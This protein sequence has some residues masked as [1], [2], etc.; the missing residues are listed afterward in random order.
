MAST[1]LERRLVLVSC[2]NPGAV[3]S[4]AIL[5][6]LL[7][8]SSW[9]KT[10][11]V[12]VYACGLANWWQVQ[13]Q[14]QDWFWYLV[15]TLVWCNFTQLYMTSFSL[16]VDSGQ[17][18]LMC[19]FVDLQVGGK[20]RLGRKIGYGILHRHWCSAIL[21]GFICP[22]PFCLSIQD[23]CPQCVCLWIGQLT[24]S[25]DWN[26]RL[27]DFLVWTLVRCNFTWAYSLSSILA[28]DYCH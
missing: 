1:D 6:S 20:Y 3:Q 21:H 28:F 5:H 9:F 26:R 11:L 23:K 19:M 27:V 22:P 15:R 7:Y 24:T 10:G 8:F 12:N 17:V 2:T 14:K 16:P 18:L 4:Y 13:T 25:T